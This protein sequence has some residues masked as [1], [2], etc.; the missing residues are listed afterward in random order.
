MGFKR[1][2]LIKKHFGRQRRC[3][4]NKTESIDPAQHYPLS[5]ILALILF[6]SENQKPAILHRLEKR[7]FFGFCPQFI[8]QLTVSKLHILRAKFSCL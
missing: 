7:T 3:K 5:Q 8:E 4:R 1:V 6:A 2:K